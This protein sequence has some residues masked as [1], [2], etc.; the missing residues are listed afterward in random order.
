VIDRFTEPYF[1]L[2]NANTLAENQ[3]LSQQ[4][5]DEQLLIKLRGKNYLVR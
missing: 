4:R 1:A 3:M 2:I 5:P